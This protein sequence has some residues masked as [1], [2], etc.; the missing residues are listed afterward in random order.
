MRQVKT[1][2][3][4]KPD[5]CVGLPGLT[6]IALIYRKGGYA[7]VMGVIPIPFERVVSDL[8]T[9]PQ[10]LRCSTNSAFGKHCDRS[11]TSR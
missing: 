9:A 10:N 11:L 6:R 1:M 7:I 8:F 4:K 2:L 3:N 5:S